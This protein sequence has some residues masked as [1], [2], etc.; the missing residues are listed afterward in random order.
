MSSA[1]QQA[2]ETS[3][4]ASQR[5]D[6]E[7]EKS[8]AAGASI[9][10]FLDYVVHRLQK[11]Q[12]HALGIFMGIGYTVA[13]RM[14]HRREQRA[15]EGRMSELTDSVYTDPPMARP[16]PSAARRLKKNARP[17]AKRWAE[18]KRGL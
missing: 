6:A 13:Y 5:T 18:K 4:E 2:C 10:S 16:K 14:L 9:D 7:L 3:L 1:E 17:A 8:V 15:K 12:A 11:S